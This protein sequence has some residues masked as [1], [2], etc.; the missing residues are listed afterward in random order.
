MAQ[1]TAQ[2]DGPFKGYRGHAMFYEQLIRMANVHAAKNAD[3]AGDGNPLAN[4]YKCEEFGIDPVD[5]CLT[6]ISDKISRITNLI[7][8]ER[9]GEMPKVA[10]SIDDTII[11]LSNYLIILTILR[12]EKAS[13]LAAAQAN[14][15]EPHHWTDEIARRLHELAPYVPPKPTAPI[16]PLDMPI[17]PGTVRRK[18]ESLEALARR[19]NGPIV[20]STPENLA[21][22]DQF[23]EDDL[24]KFGESWITDGDIQQLANNMG[25]KLSY[26]GVD[27]TPQGGN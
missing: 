13:A 5:G 11:D 14:D 6:R 26:Q 20:E 3:Y 25:V 18:H 27:Y 22:M 23:S 10:E 4:F 24:R 8:K 15:G 2:P 17:G 9:L 19:I 1:T 21:K 16:M 12:A 7:G